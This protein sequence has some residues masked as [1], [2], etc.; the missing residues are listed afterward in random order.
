MYKNVLENILGIEIYPVISLMVFVLF[1]IVLIIWTVKVNK[2][3]LN[4]MSL[5]PL[6]NDGLENNRKE[7][8][9]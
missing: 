1:F 8:I 7:M 6:E 3:Y 2:N 9:K 5:L 4:K